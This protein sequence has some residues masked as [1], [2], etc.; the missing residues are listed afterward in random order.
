MGLIDRAILQDEISQA[1]NALF[2]NGQLPRVETTKT[3]V[4]I[5]RELKLEF[6]NGQTEFRYQFTAGATYEV[7]LDGVSYVRKAFDV[8]FEGETSTALGNA[9]LF[10]Y[11]DTGEP[12]L[13]VNEMFGILSELGPGGTSEH[14][15]VF[16][17][18][19]ETETIHPIDP[20][21]LPGVCLPVVDIGDM[22]ISSTPTTITDATLLSTLEQLKKDRTPAALMTAGNPL[23]VATILTIQFIGDVCIYSGVIENTL[24]GIMYDGEKNVWEAALYAE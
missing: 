7:I 8:E 13:F 11:A 23:R 19:E 9:S 24:F 10:G 15:I 22:S 6:E 21:F 4:E 20:K 16:S 1:L 17:K 18:I 12:F 14:S 5:F 3:A 2:R